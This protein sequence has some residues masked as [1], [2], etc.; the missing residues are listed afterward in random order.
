MAPTTGSIPIDVRCVVA[1][2][3]GKYSDANCKD[4]TSL[5]PAGANDYTLLN[6]DTTNGYCKEVWTISQTTQRC[7]NIKFSVERLF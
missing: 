2:D 3:K 5:T 7:V 4:D 6:A 1:T